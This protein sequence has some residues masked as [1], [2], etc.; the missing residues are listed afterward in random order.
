MEPDAGADQGPEE[1]HRQEA[2]PH[3]RV[4]RQ[5]LRR[6]ERESRW[7]FAMSQAQTMSCLLYTSPSPRDRG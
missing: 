2:T 7:P 1:Q 3:L 4:L 6:L 5:L